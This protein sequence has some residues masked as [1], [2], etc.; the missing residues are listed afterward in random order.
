MFGRAAAAASI[1]AFKVQTAIA[2]LA[3][4]FTED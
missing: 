3:A 4:N 1:V 2:A